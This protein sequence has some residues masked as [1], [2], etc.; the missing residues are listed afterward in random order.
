MAPEIGEPFEF[1]WYANVTPASQVPGTAVRVEPTVAEPVIV[2]VGVSTRVIGV[3]VSLSR[4]VEP[5]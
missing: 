2:G 1:H 5:A 3:I 4:P